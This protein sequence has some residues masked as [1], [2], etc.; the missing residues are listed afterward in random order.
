M[1]IGVKQTGLEHLAQK[2]LK[3]RQS[4]LAMDIM[5]DSLNFYANAHVV[6]GSAGIYEADLVWASNEFSAVYL[7]VCLNFKK[8]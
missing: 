2:Y 6:S 1:I 4:W 5:R 7:T 8:T 3:A